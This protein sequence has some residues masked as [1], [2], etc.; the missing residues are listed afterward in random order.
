MKILEVG[1]AVRRRPDQY[2]LASEM[3]H[4]AGECR[5][6]FR[7]SG[8]GVGLLPLPSSLE[9]CPVQPRI[10]I[11]ELR[12]SL[13]HKLKKLKGLVRISRTIRS[14]ELPVQII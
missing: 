6:F 2:V 1:D 9:T 7:G 4:G 8:L 5:T 12:R 10:G 13:L 3:V 14:D 11:L